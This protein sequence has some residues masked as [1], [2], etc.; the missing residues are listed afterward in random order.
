VKELGPGDVADD[1]SM[2]VDE[3]NDSSLAQQDSV[4]DQLRTGNVSLGSAL[5]LSL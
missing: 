2:P 4:L 3:Q 1:K 5:L